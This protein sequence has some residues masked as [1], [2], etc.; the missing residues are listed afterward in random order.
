MLFSSTFLCPCHWENGGKD[1]HV[2]CYPSPSVSVSIRD[3]ISNLRLSFSDV[4]NLHLS[5]S[6]G[7]SMSFGHISRVFFIYLFIYY[8]N[9]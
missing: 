2:L 7:A 3:A 6:G 1:I 5:F 9:F 4:S 8:F